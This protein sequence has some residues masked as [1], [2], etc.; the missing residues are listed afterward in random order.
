MKKKQLQKIPVIHS[1]VIN[2]LEN[3]LTAD[4]KMTKRSDLSQWTLKNDSLTTYSHISRIADK[5]SKIDP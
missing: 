5:N 4:L 3:T 1:A 2:P